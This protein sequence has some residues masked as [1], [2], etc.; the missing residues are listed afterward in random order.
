MRLALALA[1]YLGLGMCATTGA[2]DVAC[3]PVK[4]IAPADQ[5]AIAAEISKLPA[6]D[7]LVMVGEDWVRMRDAARACQTTK[8]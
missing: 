4:A 5:L 2:V 7:P 8:P 1:A 3:V 6:N